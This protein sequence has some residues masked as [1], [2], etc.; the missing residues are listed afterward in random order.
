M[1]ITR[2]NNVGCPF[3]SDAYLSG[4]NR[5]TCGF[6]A[7]FH[8]IYVLAGTSLNR[9]QWWLSNENPNLQQWRKKRESFIKFVFSLE[10]SPTFKNNRFKLSRLSNKRIPEQAPKIHRILYRIKFL[11]NR[12]ERTRLNDFMQNSAKSRLG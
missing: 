7:G 4:K 11:I 12:K 2:C 5:A 3:L 8:D 6:F 10:Y 1:F 9:V